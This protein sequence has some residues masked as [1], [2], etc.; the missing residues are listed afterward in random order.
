MTDIFPAFEC[1]CQPNNRKTIF[2]SVR[3][4][5]SRKLHTD[6]CFCIIFTLVLLSLATFGGYFLVQYILMIKNG[7]DE[8][9]DIRPPPVTAFTIP[10]FPPITVPVFPYTSPE[11]PY[12][13]E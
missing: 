1:N 9:R 8:M 5:I 7:I 3:S 11:K 2:K 13:K 4:C 12:L 10:T 6:T